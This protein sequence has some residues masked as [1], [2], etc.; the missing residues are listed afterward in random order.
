MNLK[1]APPVGFE[2]TVTVLETAA[3]ITKLREHISYLSN[4]PKITTKMVLFNFTKLI[5]HTI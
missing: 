5:T 1:L 2:P 3:L 4:F